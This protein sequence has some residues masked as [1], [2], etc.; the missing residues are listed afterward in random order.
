MVKQEGC[1]CS[2][3]WKII[4]LSFIKCSIGAGS[5][6]LPYALSK[7]GYATGATSII[8]MGLISYKTMLLMVHS[9]SI[10]LDNFLLNLA[11]PL[12]EGSDGEQDDT[13]KSFRNLERPSM[14][15]GEDSAG[16]PQPSFDYISNRA[17]FIYSTL[18]EGA[19]GKMG[20]IVSELAVFLLMVGICAGYM[21]FIGSNFTSALNDLG[22]DDGGIGR[23]IVVPLLPCLLSLLRTYEILAKVASLGIFCVVGALLII[24][25]FGPIESTGFISLGDLDAANMSE[26]P[27]VLGV[28]AFL[29][30]IHPAV[31]S[32]A[33]ETDDEDELKSALG[34]GC[35]AVITVNTSLALFGYL[36][37]GDKVDGYIFCNVNSHGLITAIKFLLVVELMCSL[38]LAL[39][40]PIEIAEKLLNLEGEGNDTTKRD[41][42]RVTIV[43]L[44]YALTIG[45]PVFQ[46]LLEL[47]GGVCGGAVGFVIPPLCHARLLLICDDDLLGYTSRWEKSKAIALDFFLTSLGAC[48]MVWTMYGSIL[49]LMA[50]EDGAGDIC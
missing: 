11:D 10:I 21:I 34:W 48:V 12:L 41:V 9:K 37:W 28:S 20:R 47:V 23:L 6:G 25:T 40:P 2:K 4:V 31:M 26:L 38:P 46:D 33:E 3:A 49:K 44:S 36:L 50:P 5:F 14:K 24:F 27:G 8:I 30:A 39:R 45:V 7:A 35:F 16:A 18:G 13:R 17:L 42:V 32:M 19:W 22:L 15:G 29:L 43:L 1:G